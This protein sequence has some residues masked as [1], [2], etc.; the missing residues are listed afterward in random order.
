MNTI[1][2]YYSSVRLGIVKLTLNILSH[3]LLSYLTLRI[4]R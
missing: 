4:L 2:D 1:P 3:V